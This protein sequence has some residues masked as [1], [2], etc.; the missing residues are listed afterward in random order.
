MFS[1]CLGKVT[2]KHVRRRWPKHRV[3]L[4]CSQSMMP[5]LS[6]KGACIVNVPCNVMLQLVDKYGK[7]TSAAYDGAGSN[8]ADSELIEMAC[9]AASTTTWTENLARPVRSGFVTIRFELE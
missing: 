8:T 3:T 7:V 6:V 4:C 2:E 9:R 5:C 1:K